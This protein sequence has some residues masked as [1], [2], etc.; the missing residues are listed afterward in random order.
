MSRNNPFN[1]PPSIFDLYRQSESA[2][3]TTRRT[4]GHADNLKRLM[5]QLDGPLKTIRALPADPYRDV[6]DMMLKRIRD[7]DGWRSTMRAIE[8]ATRQRDLTL[9]AATG[10]SAL[11]EQQRLAATAF[12]SGILRTAEL[13]G[14]NRDTIATAIAAVRAQEEIAGLASSIVKRMETLRLTDLTLDVFPRTAVDRFMAEYARAQRAAAEFEAAETEEERAALLASLLMALVTALKG[15]L[16]NTRKEIIGLSALA[17]I[18]V[19][20]DVNSLLPSH[21]PPGMTAEQEHKLDE[22]RQEA[23]QIHREL[24]A[25]RESYQH[26]DEAWVSNLPRAEL[27]RAAFIR[28]EPH[29]TGKVLIKAAEGT[30]LALVRVGGKWKL[31]AFRDPLTE[32]LAQGW[33]YGQNVTVF[34]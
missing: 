24:E 15:L 16:K 31:V 17:L 7:E 20:A 4:F 27:R 34:D 12:D 14:R 18:G 9:R 30:P 29:R 6:T 26:L 13:I 19:I 21:P 8:E 28:S 32:Q 3:E 1:Q 22:T 33:V 10:F 23:K 25:L 11:Q 2:L 5:D